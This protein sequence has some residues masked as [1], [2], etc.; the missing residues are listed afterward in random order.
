MLRDNT[1]IFKAEKD[2][3]SILGTANQLAEILNVNVSSIRNLVNK[4][5]IHGY[6]V[7]KFGYYRKLYEIYDTWNNDVFYG[8]DALE[9]V[10][11]LFDVCEADIA[12]ASAKGFLVENQYRIVQKGHKVVDEKGWLIDCDY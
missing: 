7:T 6:K 2:G 1:I 8:R 10:A 9:S 3:E 4:Y 5:R 11:K 12:L